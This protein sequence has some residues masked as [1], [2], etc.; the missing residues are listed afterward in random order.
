VTN[1][2]KRISSG[3]VLLILLAF[4]ISSVSLI[5]DV[6]IYVLV[7]LT[8]FLSYEYSRFLK[9][10]SLS[11]LF[12]SVILLSVLLPSKIYLWLVILGCLIWLSLFIRILLYD[13][14]SMTNA[15]I[16][17]AGYLM[18]VPS[19][20]SGIIIFDV[21]A[22]L[23]ILILIA[24]SFA[25]SSAYFFGKKFGNKILLKNTSPG[26]TLE[27]LIGASISTPI[28][29]GLISGLVDIKLSGAILFGLIITPV[30]FIG[31]VSFSFIKRSANIKDSSN[32]IP[33][34]GG[35]IDLLD[36]SVASLPFFALL[37]MNL[38]ENF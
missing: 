33:G 13:N 26:K 38:S 4:I 20:I 10:K 32:L 21:Y 36:G 6:A 25:D 23:L 17:I 12:L 5:P 27:G 29:L 30:S 11:I 19:L 16:F 3:L 28:F 8:L 14:P 18:I 1:L 2:Q 24:V 15:E 31:D 22:K 35:F 34:H 9:E 7:L 37:L